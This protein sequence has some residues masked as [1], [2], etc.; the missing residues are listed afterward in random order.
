MG[1][2]D[3]KRKKPTNEQN[4]YIQQLEEQNVNLVKIILETRKELRKFQNDVTTIK[5]HLQNISNNI[6]EKENTTIH[7]IRTIDQI[8]EALYKITIEIN[9]LKSS[10]SNNQ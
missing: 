10:S 9:N 3:I 1:L 5:D 4:Q 2:L 7:D 8:K 6:K